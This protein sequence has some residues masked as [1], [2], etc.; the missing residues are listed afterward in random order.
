[1]ASLTPAEKLS[2]QDISEYYAESDYAFRLLFSPLNPDFEVRYAIHTIN[3]IRKKRGCR[4]TELDKLSGFAVLS[5]IEST[6]KVDYLIR[7]EDKRKDALSRRFR[8][9]F[10]RKKERISFD[11]ELI[12]S[13]IQE[14]PEHK[15]IFGDLRGAWRYRHW[16]AHGRYW[17]PKLGRKYDYFSL[18]SLAESI[19]DQLPLVSTDQYW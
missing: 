1:M 6:L 12:D 9:I 17:L 15:Q 14:H 3:E 8:A 11:T 4:L 18:H 7:C 19:H 10:K 13:W 16:L 5:S 2:L